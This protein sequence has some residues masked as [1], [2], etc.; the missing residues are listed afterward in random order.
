[1]HLS[2]RNRITLIFG[3]LLTVVAVLF[4]FISFLFAYNVEDELFYRLLQDEA[5]Y[6]AANSGA[7]PR[8][9]FIQLYP[10]IAALPEPIS[11]LLSKE[12]KRREFFTEHGLVYHIQPLDNGAYL[13]AEVS[14]RLVVRNIKQGMAFFLLIV[15]VIVLSLLLLWL[16]FMLSRQLVRPLERLVQQVEKL[17]AQ[18]P[19]PG[20]AAAF[21]NNEIGKL[22]SGLE[23]SMQRVQA[24]IDREHHFTRDLSHELR[25]PLTIINGATTL[26]KNT[27]LSAEQQQLTSRIELA[28]HQLAMTLEALLALAREQPQQQITPYRLLPLLED[29]VLLH[30]QKLAGKDIRL[31]LDVGHDIQVTQEPGLLRVLLSNLIANAF[32]YTGQ[33]QIRIY[34]QQ[35]WLMVA[36]SGDGIAA[37]IR[38]NVLE[39]GIKGQHSQGLG[40]GLSIVKRLCEQMKLAFS[41]QSDTSGTQVGIKLS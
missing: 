7:S 26:L 25:T 32:A 12:P 15:L 36:D 11:A 14:D 9:E 41:L 10:D 27:G 30:H 24:F 18:M 38:A 21:S 29:C 33:G 8:L 2:L 37:E 28:Q 23:Q 35:G 5:S 17:P 4:G 39:A 20:F 19:E 13:V 34:V 16:V 22:A 3:G 6:L 31:L 1:M 40:L